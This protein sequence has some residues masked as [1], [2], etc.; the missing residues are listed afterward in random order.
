MQWIAASVQDGILN[1]WC[2]CF[3]DFVDTTSVFTFYW[4]AGQATCLVSGSSRNHRLVKCIAH[5]L[6]INKS[7]LLWSPY[8]AIYM[9][10]IMTYTCGLILSPVLRYPLLL[11]FRQIRPAQWVDQ[12]A[13]RRAQISPYSVSKSG[14]SLSTNPEGGKPRPGIGNPVGRRNAKPTAT[15]RS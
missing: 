10:S 5:Q 13:Q 7:E 14:E 2:Q 4:G 3:S 15:E 9:G 1:C 8:L 11:L 12:R 6:D